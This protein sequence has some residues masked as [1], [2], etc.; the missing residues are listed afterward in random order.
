[1]SI[2]N[3]IN[4]RVVEGRLKPLQPRMARDRKIRKLFF[5]ID[6]YDEIYCTVRE[7]KTEI[8]NFA[9][10]Q[11]DL[12]VFVVSETLDPGYIWLLKPKT[13]GIW[14]IRSS[15]PFPQIRVFGVFAARDIFV[16]THLA[17]RDTLGDVR[18]KNWD[19]EMKRSKREWGILFPA[20]QFK[21]SSDVNKLF[22]GALNEQY[23]KS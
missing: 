11:A 16:A 17:S 3:E 2:T 22:S 10:L 20:H 18:S 4:H 23:F 15:R 21:T 19:V 12:E 5:T 14:E 6:L 1:M 13:K 8:A 7:N 9:K